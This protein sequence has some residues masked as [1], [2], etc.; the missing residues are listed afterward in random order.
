MVAFDLIYEELDNHV[1]WM[2]SSLKLLTQ[3][4]YL[5]IIPYDALCS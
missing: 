2:G 1:G 5:S 4:L 3:I